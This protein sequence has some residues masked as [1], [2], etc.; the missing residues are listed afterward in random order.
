MIFPNMALLQQYF[1]FIECIKAINKNGKRPM[2]L[3]K[4]LRFEFFLLTQWV[5][6]FIDEDDVF[7]HFLLQSFGSVKLVGYY[8]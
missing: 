5:I 2:T 7:Y 4:L 1:D 6:V 3:C 8:T